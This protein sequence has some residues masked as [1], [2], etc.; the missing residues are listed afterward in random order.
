MPRI[1]GPNGLA[2]PVSDDIAASLLRHRDG[3]YELV[4]PDGTDGT[5]GEPK[6]AAKKTAAKKTA[7]AKSTDTNG[8]TG[9]TPAD[10]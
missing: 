10:V 8:A 3:E 9:S 4:D 5:D 7:A 6:P 2:I 1:K